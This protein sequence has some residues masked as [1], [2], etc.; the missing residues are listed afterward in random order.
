MPVVTPSRAAL[1]NAYDRHQ[2]YDLV[3]FRVRSRGGASNA[4]EQRN[5]TNSSL[6]D[7]HFVILFKDV[8]EAKKKI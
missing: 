2:V 4:D 7:S 8:R 1:K 3:R 5:Q 6:S